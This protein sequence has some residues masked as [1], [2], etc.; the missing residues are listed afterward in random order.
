MHPNACDQWKSVSLITV[1]AK[2]MF[3]SA[4]PGANGFPFGQRA[5]PR[6]ALAAMEW[7]SL[8]VCVSAC[9]C[10]SVHMRPTQA[11]YDCQIRSVQLL[12]FVFVLMRRLSADAALRR[13][14]PLQ[15]NVNQNQISIKNN[16]NFNQDR[17]Q[18]HCRRQ[19]SLSMSM[20]LST[21]MII[22]DVNVTV[23]VKAMQTL[24]SNMLCRG[25]L[26]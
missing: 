16:A 21:S 24:R 20:S 5:N 7:L 6:R 13:G 4:N 14:P 11:S 17:C 9:L 26:K 3:I 23:M 10:L 12:M 8:H 18:C 15:I 1:T 25:L 22:V 2:H 19:W